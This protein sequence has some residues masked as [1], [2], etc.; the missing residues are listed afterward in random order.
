MTPTKRLAARVLVLDPDGHVLLMRGFD[1]SRPEAG[2]WWLTPGGGVDAGE[3]LEDAARRELREETG[4]EVDAV[5]A[6]VFERRVLFDFEADSFDQT[7]HFFCVRAERF[8]ITRAGW[9]DLEQRSFLEHRWWSTDELAV[10]AETIYPEDLV[11]RLTRLLT[12]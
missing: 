7:E 5:G 1:P 6:P 11:E 4:L 2:S 9:T 8:T 10:T 12:S 3:S